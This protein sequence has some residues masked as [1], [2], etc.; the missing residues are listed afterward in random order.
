LKQ[1]SAGFPAE[2]FFVATS[3]RKK[4][5]RKACPPAEGGPLLRAIFRKIFRLT[6]KSPSSIFG[7]LGEERVINIQ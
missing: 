2:P 5:T 7:A 4:T 1:G 6:I 3:R